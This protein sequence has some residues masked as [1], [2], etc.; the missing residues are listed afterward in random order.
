MPLRP[1]RPLP[2]PARASTL[3]TAAYATCCPCPWPGATHR[4]AGW[5]ATPR[6]HGLTPASRPWPTRR[7]ACPA[8]WTLRRPAR[9]PALQRQ[10]ADAGT[11]P[12]PGRPAADRCSDADAPA[13][14]W[15]RAACRARHCAGQLSLR[16]QGG[17]RIV[18]L[19]PQADTCCQPRSRHGRAHHSPDQTDAAG[20]CWSAWTPPSARPASA[21]GPTICAPASGSGTSRSGASGAA[22]P[23]PA[24]WTCTRTAGQPSTRTT[25]GRNRGS[26]RSK[27]FSRAWAA[28][29]HRYR[30]IATRPATDVHC[31]RSLWQVFRPMATGKPVQA[32]VSGIVIDDTET[33]RLVQSA[34][35]AQSQ[36]NLVLALA[37][38]AIWEHDAGTSG[39]L[40]TSTLGWALLGMPPQPQGLPL[41]LAAGSAWTADSRLRPAGGTWVTARRPTWPRSIL[42]T[43]ADGPDRP[44]TALPPARRA[45]GAPC[46][47]TP[48]AP[49]RDSAGPAPWGHVGV[50]LDLSDR[51]D[52]QQQAL[53]LAR[54]LEMA[55]GRRRRGGVER[56]AGRP[57]AGAL[58]CADAPAARHGSPTPRRRC[59]AATSTSMCTQSDRATVRQQ[60]GRA[61]AKRNE[62]LLDMDLRV[63]LPR[64]PGA[65]PGHPHLGHAC[66]QGRAPAATAWCW[67]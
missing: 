48:C 21:A 11:A 1:A 10:A 43:D 54:R 47:H 50:M 18:T 66:A 61:A 52:A 42:D 60:P 19:L 6:L 27:S 24:R 49:V 65:A 57:A 35:D 53:A 40:R 3:D 58:G 23:K 8:I 51:F 7:A 34:S 36:L 20:P 37:D 16:C 17:W 14:A 56:G 28:T 4:A 67:T 25:A 63:V 38:I 5:D 33:F 41:A 9:P 39:L 12:A 44:G 59:C 55:T 2:H 46:W 62:G 45:A 26:C 15:A 29:A 64:R 32:H 31:M 13:L 22:R 30:L